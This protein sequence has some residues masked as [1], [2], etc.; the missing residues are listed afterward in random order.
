M[1]DI[2]RVPNEC[3]AKIMSSQP[4][5]RPVSTLTNDNALSLQAST[6]RS[7]NHRT[8]SPTSA[9]PRPVTQRR[10]AADTICRADAPDTPQSPNYSLS[11][12]S[13]QPTRD[14]K[15]WSHTGTHSSARGANFLRPPEAQQSR[16]DSHQEDKPPEAKLSSPTPESVR[17]LT[18]D[19]TAVSSYLHDIASPRQYNVKG[20]PWLKSNSQ[21]AD[22]STGAG[23]ELD[24]L[25]S[26]D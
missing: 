19:G 22:D 21:L 20:S 4:R 26:A 13:S 2:L 25:V 10:L 8:R 1:G 17:E 15:S 12:I 6:P 16:R 7:L 24:L 23:A 9:L 11:K 14:A 5:N 3:K 18:Y